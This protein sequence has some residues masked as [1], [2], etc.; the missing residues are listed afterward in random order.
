MAIYQNVSGTIKLLAESS[1]G[2]SGAYNDLTTTRLYN[3]VVTET[4]TIPEGYTP[5]LIIVCTNDMRTP[6]ITSTGSL[7]YTMNNSA[8]TKL[9]VSTSSNIITLTYTTTNVNLLTA[10][11]KVITSRVTAFY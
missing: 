7:E 3:S 5:K 10:A 4:F 8:S 6:Q 2:L 9:T 1:G 11:E